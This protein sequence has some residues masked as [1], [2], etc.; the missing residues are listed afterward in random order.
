MP[1][2]SGGVEPAI[3]Q[4]FGVDTDDVAIDVFSPWCVGRVRVPSRP[5]LGTVIAKWSRP[6]SDSRAEDW[7]LAEEAAALRFL[8]EIGSAELAPGLIGVGDGVLV[9]K[10]AGPSAS[11]W[12]LLGTDHPS[13]P[14]AYLD[15]ARTMGHMHAATVGRQ[16]EWRR[17]RNDFGCGPGPVG[18]PQAGDNNC[19]LRLHEFE[20]LIPPTVVVEREL[21]HV[22]AALTAPG[23][24]AALSNGDP[25]ANNFL[26]R[27]GGGWIIDFEAARYRH[28]LID[29]AC[30]FVQ[31]S[32][33]TTFARPHRYGVIEAYRGALSRTVPQAADDD[34]FGF[35]VGGTV[36]WLTIQRL[37]RFQK[38]DERPPGHERRAQM[39]AT[40]ESA[41]VSLREF[42]V[43]AAL[44]DWLEEASV[45]L[46]SRWPDTDMDF[47]DAFIRP[48]DFARQPKR[49]PDAGSR[50][51]RM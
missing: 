1:V 42:Q 34:L 40:L 49:T 45:R 43:L 24:F 26:A 20:N 10:D 12:E 25:G 23:Q 22:R 36:A 2:G 13:A 33:W 9:M 27:A 32:V 4:V 11:L 31:H 51:T 41:V 35:V 28:A 3:A 39:V 6:V 46:R 37:H 18:L 48:D 38:N 21:D 8:Q 29:V 19:T 7:L 17:F 16:E 50:A 15:F 44:A 47:P 14:Q 5:E 30:L